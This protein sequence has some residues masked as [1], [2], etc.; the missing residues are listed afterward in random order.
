MPPASRPNECWSMDFTHDA[1]ES[2]RAFRTLNVVDVVTRM[3]LA[4]EVAASLPAARVVRVLDR[5]AAAHGRPGTP[6]DNPFIES[7]ND[8][9]RDGCLNQQWFGGPRFT[10]ENW[11]F[12]YNLDRPLIS[13]GSLTPCESAAQASAG[14]RSAPRPTGPLKLEEPATL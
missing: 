7:F 11:R 9:F 3:C 2:G 6:T 14:L 5:L 13:L 10:I 8:R 12:D 1:L 4:I